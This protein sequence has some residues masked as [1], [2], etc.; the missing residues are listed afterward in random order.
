MFAFCVITFEQIKIQ[1]CSAPQNDHLNLS[2]VK[3]NHIVGKQSGQKWQQNGHLSCM[4]HFR[5]EF[6]LPLL[7]IVVKLKVLVLTHVILLFVS[8]RL[9]TR[10]IFF[11]YQVFFASLVQIAEWSVREFAASL[12]FESVCRCPCERESFAEYKVTE[13]YGLQSLSANSTNTAY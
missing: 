9:R 7:C 1:T 2:F 4:I 12:E 8:I 3:D 6:R 10:T 5:S 13:C 11:K